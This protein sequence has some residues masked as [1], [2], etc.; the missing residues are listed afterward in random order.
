[1]QIAERR[2]AEDIPSLK[3]PE[4]FFP[5]RGIIVNWDMKRHR[6]QKGKAVVFTLIILYYSIYI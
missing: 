3:D 4:L 6:A 5:G 2:R 1:M